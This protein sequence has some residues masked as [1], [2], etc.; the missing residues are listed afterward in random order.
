MSTR[1]FIV[2]FFFFVCVFDISHHKVFS[3]IISQASRELSFPGIPLS[4][5][6]KCDAPLGLNW[7]LN[8]PGEFLLS[9][10]WHRIIPRTV[11]LKL[12]V[13]LI[14][15]H[16]N[17]TGANERFPSPVPRNTSPGSRSQ[18]AAAAWKSLLPDGS[19]A[20]QGDLTVRPRGTV[21]IAR[22]VRGSGMM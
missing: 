9:F 19:P 12:Q 20:P 8:K 17:V 15:A 10:L 7:G 13:G 22:D 1:T 5:W 11:G 4:S 21:T 18:V 2:T 6:D 3:D 16:G 14:N